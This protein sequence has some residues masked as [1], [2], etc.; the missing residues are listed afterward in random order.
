MSN[1]GFNANKREKIL[2][3][4]NGKCFYCNKNLRANHFVAKEEVI[5]KLMTVDHIHPKSKNGSNKLDNLIPSCYK[6]NQ[7]KADKILDFAL[8]TI[9]KTK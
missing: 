6:C 8:N 1:M 7:N 4:T 2:E 9:E 5:K 3:K